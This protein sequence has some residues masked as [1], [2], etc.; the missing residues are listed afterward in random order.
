MHD[1][2]RKFNTDSKDADPR[3][4]D[5]DD[6]AGYFGDCP[7][8]HKNDD[9]LNVGNDHWFICTEHKTKW[10]IGANLFSS[11]M[12]ETAEQQRQEQEQMGF[13][14]FEVVE[15]FYPTPP[16]VSDVTTIPRQKDNQMNFSDE[17]RIKDDG[18]PVEHQQSATAPPTATSENQLENLDTSFDDPRL[19]AAAELEIKRSRETL[20]HKFEALQRHLSD[21]AKIASQIRGLVHEDLD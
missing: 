3:S 21:A 10:C 2:A 5:Q 11:S 13:D 6:A 12:D 19:E 4:S 7:I 9:Y 17:A 18:I 8:C 20:E 15:P 1:D 16:S 14:S